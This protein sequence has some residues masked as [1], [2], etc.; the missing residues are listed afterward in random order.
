MKK[1]N[2]YNIDILVIKNLKTNCS[3][4][5]IHHTTNNFEHTIID[6][7]PRVYCLTFMEKCVLFM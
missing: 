6:K 3:D 4:P 5:L 7:T 1:I 2:H